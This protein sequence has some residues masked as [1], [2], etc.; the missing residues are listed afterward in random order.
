MNV[1]EVSNTTGVTVNEDDIL[2]YYVWI[3]R[4]KYKMW[5]VDNESKTGQEQEIQIVFENKNDIA[6]VPNVDSIISCASLESPTEDNYPVMALYIV[7][8]LSAVVIVLA[9]V[10]LLFVHS[11]HMLVDFVIRKLS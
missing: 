5:S 10:V 6:Y 7:L 3:P 8:L 4:Y 11:Y 1:Q 9:T 2:A